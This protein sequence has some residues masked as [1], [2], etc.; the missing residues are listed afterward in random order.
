MKEWETVTEELEIGCW[1]EN[2][3]SDELDYDVESMQELPDQEDVESYE[4]NGYEYEKDSQ[5]HIL[6]AGGD[7]RLEEGIRNQS[8]QLQAGGADRRS[9]DDGGHLIGARFGGAGDLDNLVAENC[10]VNRGV[11]KTLEDEWADELEKGNQVHVEIQPQYQ[12]MTERPHII[13][14][15][16]EFSNGEGTYTDYF[17]ITNENLESEE[18]AFDDTFRNESEYPNVMDDIQDE[19]EVELNETFNRNEVK[20]IYKNESELY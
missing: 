10:K 18:F 15:T 16:A 3:L 13:M 4:K 12:N 8:A 17:S 6:Y 14:G 1:D 19:Y 11:F 5:G 9:D 2:N 7:L 20:K